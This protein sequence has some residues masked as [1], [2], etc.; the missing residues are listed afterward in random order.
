MRIHGIHLQGIRAPQGEHRIAFDPGYNAVLG[1]DLAE[2]QAVLGLL[3]ALLYPAEGAEA[4]STYGET[5]DGKPA[6]AGLSLS[7]GAD[8]YRVIADMAQQRLLLGRYDSARRTYERVAT[9]PLSIEEAL[10]EAGLPERVPF[11]ILNCWRTPHGPLATGGPATPATPTTPA[12]VPEPEEPIEVAPIEAEII[13]DEPEAPVAAVQPPPPDPKRLAERSGL[14]ARARTLRNARERCLELEREELELAAELEKR[15]SLSDALDELGPRVERYREHSSNRTQE[16]SGVEAQRRALLDERGRLRGIPQAQAS[17]MWLGVALGAAGALAGW[18]VQPLFYVLGGIGAGTALFGLA[19]SR[20]ARR[21][22]GRVEARLAAVRVREASIERRFESETAPLRSLM[23]ALE[24]EEVETLEHDA[25]E[26]SKLA[27]RA[28]ELRSELDD[29]RRALGESPDS[30]LA[31]IEG[32][33]AELDRVAAQESAVSAPPAQSV[34]PKPTPAPTPAPKP[35][36]KRAVATAA[37]AKAPPTPMAPTPMVPTTPS[38]AALDVLMQAAARL[39]DC[40]EDQVRA[41]LAPVLPIYLRALS[42]GT[43][44]RAWYEEGDG[45]YLRREGEDTRVPFGATAAND[46]TCLELAFRL[47]LLEALAPGVRFPL[48]VGPEEDLF[49]G[50]RA[51]TFAR[52]LKRLGAVVQVIQLTVADGPWDQ[53]ASRSYALSR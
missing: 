47:G 40:G 18:L 53:Y 41:Q 28:D 50:E 11:Q 8:A 3:T 7:F 15:S 51:E 6:R 23:Q 25:A 30:E 45:W 46:R 37:S 4:L 52:A 42:D 22:L 32:R 36:R 20:G 17:G 33:I 44:T 5:P 43:Y 12:T 29:A 27:S 31:T 35:T 49:N 39:G 34:A 16:R 19:V 13:R 48:V 10:R 38:A 14:E 24:V 2:T 21:R 26:Y 9:E 1:S